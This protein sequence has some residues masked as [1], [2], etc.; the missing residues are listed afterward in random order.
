MRLYLMGADGSD[1]RPISPSSGDGY[2]FVRPSWSPDASQIASAVVGQ[3]TSDIVLVEADGSGETTLTQRFGGDRPS[4]ATDGSIG[5]VGEGE[6]PCCMQVREADGD[7]LA[8][9]G[10]IPFWSPDGALAVTSAS[11][12]SPDLMIV[13]RDGTVVATIPE[14]AWP[15]WQRLAP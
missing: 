6:E 10:G 1:V 13:A 8:L 7:H 15:S 12:D 4:F 2:S 5:W 9:P 11:D 14:A 3:F